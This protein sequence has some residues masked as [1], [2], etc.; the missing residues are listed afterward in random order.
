MNTNRRRLKKLIKDENLKG[1]PKNAKCLREILH[2]IESISE[3]L[4][5]KKQI[6]TPIKK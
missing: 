1:N 5:E 6:F 2:L 3:N 4:P